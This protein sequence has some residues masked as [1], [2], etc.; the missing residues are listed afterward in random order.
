MSKSGVGLGI[1]VARSHRR[2]Q[3]ADEIADS[4]PFE[5]A[6]CQRAAEIHG[7]NANASRHQAIDDTF[8][9]SG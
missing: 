5:R 7:G 4:R 9:E 6:E 2:R 3:V 1:T 8:A